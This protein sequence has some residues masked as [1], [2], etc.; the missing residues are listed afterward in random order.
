[1]LGTGAIAD[2]PRP[3]SNKESSIRANGGRGGWG[4]G[5][6]CRAL[7]TYRR[8]YTPHTDT[9]ASTA[10]QRRA[11]RP[12]YTHKRRTVT[13][14]PDATPP[15]AHVART[16]QVITRIEAGH[17]DDCHT[18]NQRGK[19]TA[20]SHQRA[21]AEG[22][23]DWVRS[24]PVRLVG[25]PVGHSRALCHANRRYLIVQQPP[26]AVEQEGKVLEPPPGDEQARRRRLQTPCR[27]IGGPEV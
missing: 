9:T 11:T 14:T 8:S 23:S 5:T 17:I 18:D 25:R 21:S 4:V 26:E 22:G 15:A 27:Y 16:A 2:S 13:T 3:R 12:T 19:K 7:H 24:G 1:M 6:H 20:P 10:R